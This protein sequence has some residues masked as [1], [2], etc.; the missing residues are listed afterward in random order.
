[1]SSVRALA[2]LAVVAAG[3]VAFV[4]RVRH[5]STG[6]PMAGGI[7]MP[8]AGAYDRMSGWLFG[9]LFGPIAADAAAFAVP[10]ARVLEVGCGPGHL[11]RRLASEHD[12]EVTGLDLDPAMIERARV[13]A[14]LSAVVGRRTATFIVG[15]VAEL[16]LPD[17]SFHLVVSTFSMHH[18]ADPVAGLTEINRVLRPD[19]RALVWDLRHGFSLF[20][21]RSPDPLAPVAASPLELIEARSWRWPWRL[22]IA[23]RLELGRGPAPR[24]PADRAADQD[25][26]IV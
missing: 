2:A 6:R 10:G 12:L 16:P 22:S 14:E 9:S 26:A 4:H 25:P 20:H 18:W 11:A 3:L 19:G 5:H 1:M 15:D 21:F 8:D 17:A 7:V 24:T 23:Q 13:N